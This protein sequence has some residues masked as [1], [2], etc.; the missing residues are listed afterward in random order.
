MKNGKL[1]FAY[2][3]F[4]LLLSLTFLLLLTMANTSKKNRSLNK[5]MLAGTHLLNFTKL[6]WQNNFR[7]SFGYWL[8]FLYTLCI[9][10]LGSI[11]A[12]PEYVLYHRKIKNTPIS[13]SPVF[14]IGHW[15]T[16][17]TFLHNLMSH[18]KRFGCLSNEYA[19]LPN[20]MFLFRPI[21][22]L[23]FKL[24]MPKYRPMDKVELR[25]KGPQEDELALCGITHRAAYHCWSFPQRAKDYLFKW[26]LLENVSEKEIAGFKKD[27]MFLLKK[28]T[29]VNN[30]RQ[31]VLKNPANTGRI[32]LLLELFPDAKFIYTTRNREEV[33]QSSFRL[34]EK[35]L[36]VTALQSYDVN[37]FRAIV[38]EL[39]DALLAKYEADKD[40]IKPGN[41]VEIKYEDLVANPM[42]VLNGIYNNLGLD[43]F[44][45][46]KPEFLNFLETQRSY[47]PANYNL[48]NKKAPSDS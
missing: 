11:A 17:T 31:L 30:G 10:I 40:A 12:L 41:L 21:V 26:C 32:K 37:T 46:A 13:K 29:L 7:I 8:R 47:K 45:K 34:H 6:L 5:Q 33:E 1:F 28:A 23:F 24:N 25:I 38:P 9:L 22:R 48:E 4:V 36:E 20:L 3:L 2:A 14:I 19:M 35:T 44:E 15:R 16:G 27:F 43:S 18:D 39:Y 42:E